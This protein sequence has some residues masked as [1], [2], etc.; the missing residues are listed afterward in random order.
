MPT[1]RRLALLLLLA[2]PLAACGK[3]PTPPSKAAEPPTVQGV[4]VA[5]VTA[6][7]VVET[8]EVTGTVK[9]QTATTLSS[10]I[11][12]RI[13][14]LHAREGGEVKAGQLLVEL[15]DQ[16]ILMQLRRAEAGLREA[17][18]A[19]AEV[20]RSLAAVAATRAAAESQR[21]LAAT[22]LAR[23]QQLLDKKSV[24]PQEFDQVAARHKAA[25]ADVERVIAEGQVV[26]A[27]RQQVLARIESAKAEIASVQVRLGYAKI[28][29]PMAGVVVMK[30]ADVGALAAPGAP[31]LTIEDSRHYWLDAAVPESQLAGIRRGQALRVAV[32]AAGLNARA[33]VSEILPVADP[34]TRTALV[35]LELPA[36]GGLRSGLFG[37]IWIP[38]GR[39]QV[40][41]VA[42]EA[43]VERG[44]LQGVY[45][46]GT[47]NIA[48]F[49]LIRTGAARP[50]GLEVLSGL[51]AGEQVVLRG[52]ERVQDGSRIQ[53]EGK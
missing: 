25:A 19:V 21:D 5:A 13:L 9:S 53:Q 33:T 28:I 50:G 38:A 4:T 17:E 42:R 24:A 12:S 30:H 23:Y 41:Q 35:R 37:R 8:A 26:L 14:A 52:S 16:D 1:L 11:V 6:Q 20:D 18:A 46:V 44:Q 31:L 7:E 22:T 27:R 43:L 3:E 36:R 49:R 48:R 40:L 51:S 10:K 47:D 34:G 32:E 39:R 15:D 2:I 45:V 29:A